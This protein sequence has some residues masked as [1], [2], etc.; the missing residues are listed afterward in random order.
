M[1]RIPPHHADAEASILGGVL[2]RNAVLDE[3]TELCVEDFFVPA[4]RVVFSAM[5][6]L[7]ARAQP[8]DTVTLEAEIAKAG[9]LAAIGGV[10]F[11]GEL[12]LRV[13]T[14]DNVAAYAA[15]VQA[16]SLVRDVMGIGGDLVERGYEPDLDTKDYLD[17]AEAQILAATARR[18]KA[19]DAQPIGALASR[20][21]RELDDI[22]AARARG[23]HALTGAP[24]GVAK[25]DERLGGW[26]FG[27][28]NLLAARP[29]MG[30]SATALAS[31]EAAAEAGYGVHVFSLEDPARSYADRNLARRT[32][33]PAEKLRQAE[34][35]R[36]HA[37]L[38][39][40]AQV[41][42]RQLSERWLVDS[43]GGLTAGEIVRSVRR[44]RER[45]GTR[46]VVVDYVQL[47][48][49]TPKLDENAAID[50]II[51]TFASAAKELDGSIA[52]L[53]LSQ[54]NRKV[55]ERADKRPQLSDLRGSGALEERPKVIVG[56]YRG[57]Y[58]G[59]EPV[60]DVDYDCWC[61]RGT[62]QSACP[63]RPNTEDFERQ[64]QLLLM[65][66]NNGQTGRV[67]AHWYGPTMEIR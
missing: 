35:E 60:K 36:Q 2:L 22:A 27:V 8:I 67:F 57:A 50:E 21:V 51:T 26:Q 30:K 29:A 12:Q 17:E 47:V 65:K 61:S 55:E 45:L 40:Q 19:D 64:V 33:I 63:H 52:W 28:V 6:N 46:L 38:L 49:R 58:Y 56:Q 37:S 16:S 15:L 66:N 62:P 31:S 9:K 34:L 20:R 7:E 25:L 48:K 32:G 13:P 3:L 54:M 42:L 59:S 44:H 53:V 11:L 4:H 41:Q 1:T 10:A 18:S 14:V 23:D 5:R 43:R 39:L 24:T